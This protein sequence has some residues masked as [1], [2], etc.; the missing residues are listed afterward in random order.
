MQIQTTPLAGAV[1]VDVRRLED[2]R[3]FFARTFCRQ[4]FL[5]AGLDPV[6]EQANIS[7]NHHAGTLRGF[8]YQLD[9]NA[10][11]KLVRCS[12][13]AIYD[14]IVDLRPESPTYLEHFGVELTED[15]RTALYVPR[16]FAHS[17]VT[18]VAGAEVHYQVTTAYAPGFER[19]LRFDDPTLGVRWPV[20]ITTISA[21]DAAWP[22]LSEVPL[23]SE[24]TVD[25][26]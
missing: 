14:V 20:A 1:L 17:Y 23:L 7:F 4:E 22:L 10:E 15:N 21:K 16:H 6:V 2:Q 12:R 11:A 19:G 25:A 8:H 9:P 26:R 24:A 13:G 18:L 5:D 3:G